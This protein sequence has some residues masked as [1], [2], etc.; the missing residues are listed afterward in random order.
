MRRQIFALAF[1]SL[2][3]AAAI[4]AAQGGKP[5]PPPASIEIDAL[6]RAVDPCVDFYQFACGG[7]IKKNPLPADRRSW[8]RFQEVQDRNFTIL[9][10]ILETPGTESSEGD[11]GKAADYYAACMDESGI[12][13]TGLAPL[14]PDLATIAAL[15]NPDDLPVLVAHLHSFG[16]QALFRFG[17]QTD[18][19]DATQQIA[20]VDQSGL[21]LPDRETYLKTDARSADQRDKY[22]AH[23]EKMFAMANV[24]ADRATAEAKAVLAFE[25]ALANAMLDRVTRRDPAATHHPMTPADLQ[26]FTPNF[27]WKKY[28]A[29]A[30][31]PAF[32]AI[33]V[34]VPEYM[35]ALDG[36]ITSTPVG[37]LK[38]YLRWHLLH[39]SA[40][41]LPKRFADAEFDFFSRTLAGQQAELP[42]WRR[43]VAESDARLGEALGKAF[44]EEAFS[45]QAKADMLK[46]VRGIKDAMRQD[47]DAAT[48]MSGET[49]KA[50]TAKLDAVVDRIGYPDTW[51]DYSAL[52]VTRDDALGNRQRAL[53]FNR[54]RTLKKIGRPVDRGE[55]SMTPPTADAYY[56]PDRNNINFP[57][58]IL[59]PPFYRAG[60]DAAVNYG[61]VGAV[62]GH[63]LT[64]CFDDQ[65]RHFDGQGNLRDWWTAADGK[66]FEERARCVADQYSSYTVAGDTRINGRLTLGEN[67]ADNGGLR[68]ALMAYLAGPG[69]RASSKVDGFTG[70]QRVFLGWAHVWCE[71]TRPEAER[72]NAF[73]TSNKYRVNGPLSNMPEFRKAFSC[74]P[75]APMVRQNAC[76]VW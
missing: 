25:T 61:G 65:G 10:R 8:G 19:R 29:A 41:L 46:M 53:A 11:R 74:K 39:A 75:N 20:D 7:W 14:G 5:A 4:A 36:L 68:L 51:R 47:I 67:I 70:D 63:E 16:V 57:A 12:E 49:K 69:A 26:A 66:A 18:L 9:R 42:R 72:L 37:D 13:A 2:P 52:R 50:A 56:S 24:E 71:N 1:V 21:G 60:R 76:R 31:A 59:Q 45:P 40:D 34:S 64:H 62:I 38:A 54:E 23:M 27:D 73:R 43:C 22:V 15:T 55:W 48:W 35:K 28:A 3:L 32:H 44:V 33:N 17:A 58:G 30:G 6:D